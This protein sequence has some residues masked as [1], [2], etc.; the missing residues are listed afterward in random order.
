MAAVRLAVIPRS[1]R[2][3][4]RARSRI[5]NR[6]RPFKPTASSSAKLPMPTPLPVLT[7]PNSTSPTTFV[8]NTGNNYMMGG[9][10]PNTYLFTETN[11]GHDT[12]ANFNI[13]ADHVQ[14]APNLNGNGISSA[15]QLIAGATVSNGNTVLHL[16]PK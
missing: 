13:S 14:I 12:I 4:W 1:P 8:D 3:L 7:G 6:R 15:S 5:P 11:S 2:Q 9:G 10:G 16:S